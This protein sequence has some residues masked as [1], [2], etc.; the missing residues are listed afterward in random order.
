MS[1]W[2][3][4]LMILI[5]NESQCATSEGG[6]ISEHGHMETIL[7]W[8]ANTLKMFT[9]TGRAATFQQNST[10]WVSSGRG[11][12]IVRGCRA[13]AKFECTWFS[14]LHRSS[15]VNNDRY[16]TT[17]HCIYA[18]NNNINVYAYNCFTFFSTILRAMQYLSQVVTKRF[19]LDSDFDNVVSLIYIT[20]LYFW[21]FNSKNNDKIV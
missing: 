2:T 1:R 15:A 12:N 18:R 4:K 14:H 7:L 21:H 10:A 20:Y 8:Q 19:L 5:E 13:G 3:I 11:R 9:A 17:L 16:L 6:Q